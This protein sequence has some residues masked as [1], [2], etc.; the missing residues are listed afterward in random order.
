MS[1]LTTIDTAELMDMITEGGVLIRDTG[2]IAFSNQRFAQL[3]GVDKE[4]LAGMLFSEFVVRQDQLRVDEFLSGSFHVFDIVHPQ[5]RDQVV[6]FYQNITE[7]EFDALEYRIVSADGQTKW[8]HDET[9][10]IYKKG[11]QGQN[12]KHSAL[13]PGHYGTQNAHAA[14]HRGPGK[15]ENQRTAI[16]EYR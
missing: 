6:R 11:G 9:E 5:D 13:H 4:T 7:K 16:P 12:R 2:R 14:P 8:V 1:P 10:V 15:V 3:T